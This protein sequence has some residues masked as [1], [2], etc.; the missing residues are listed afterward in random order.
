VYRREHLRELPLAAV[1]LGSR[2]AEGRI[3]AVGGTIGSLDRIT[4]SDAGNGVVRFE[5]HN[6]MDWASALRIPGMEGWLPVIQPGAWGPGGALDM[7]F[8][9]V[10]QGP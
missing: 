8:F 3:D 6:R 7:V 9:W 1:G 4:V 2:T 5:V 10:E